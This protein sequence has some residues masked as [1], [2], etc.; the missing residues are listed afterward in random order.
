MQIFSA[1]GHFQ[2]VPVLIPRWRVLN[3]RGRAPPRDSCVTGLPMCCSYWGS[4]V[5][6]LMLFLWVWRWAY[7]ECVPF[8]NLILPTQP[9]C[10]Q[11][12][13]EEPDVGKSLVGWRGAACAHLTQNTGVRL[14]PNMVQFPPWK[15]FRA[16]PSFGLEKV[17][18]LRAGDL[19]SARVFG[20]CH[21]FSAKRLH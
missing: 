1:F 10:P 19:D 4:S 8:I 16:C 11:S 14:A 21:F 2:A 18:C 5:Q 13:R 6:W 12:A 20:W 3:T 7:G 15:D 9:K 17:L